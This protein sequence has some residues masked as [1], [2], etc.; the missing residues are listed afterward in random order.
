MEMKE[1]FDKRHD[2]EGGA[3]EGN[4]KGSI[5]AVFCMRIFLS[6]AIEAL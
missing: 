3:D 5:S 6:K 1:T 4:G 2:E